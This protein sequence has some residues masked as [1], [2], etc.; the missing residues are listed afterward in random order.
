MNGWSQMEPY[1][2]PHQTFSQCLLVHAKLHGVGQI[3]MKGPLLAL[4][5]KSDLKYPSQSPISSEAKLVPHHGLD[6]P[7]LPSA[8]V[9]YR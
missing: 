6:S 2:F 9:F 7:L 4:R 5:F 3:C 1:W 8:H